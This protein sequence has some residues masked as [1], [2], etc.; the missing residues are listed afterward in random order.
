MAQ[1][2]TPGASSG[3]ATFTYPVSDGALT[4][5][6]TVTVTVTDPPAIGDVSGV[7]EIVTT[8]TSATELAGPGSCDASDGDVDRFYLTISQTGL[9]LSARAQSGE[10]VTGSI[11]SGTGLATLTGMATFIEPDLSNPADD[12]DTTSY[13]D[14]HALVVSQPTPSTMTGSLTTNESWSG[15]TG[16]TQTPQCDIVSSVAGTF[17]YRHTETENYS[18]V[19]G[20][21]LF[22]EEEGSDGSFYAD[23]EGFPF[24]IEISGSTLN[25]HFPDEF[26]P[27]GT[28]TISAQSFEPA[29]GYFTF[30]LDITEKYGSGGVFD[31]SETEHFVA[32]GIFVR[33]PAL[34]NGAD[35]APLVFVSG[36]GFSRHYTGEVGNGGT[37][38][39]AS[40]DYT[41]G[42]GKRLTTAGQ[43][44]TILIEG[45]DQVDRSPI[46]VGLDNPPLKRLNTTTSDLWIEVLNAD[47]TLL[48]S[49]LYTYDGTN[50]LGSPDSFRYFEQIDQPDPDF[51]ALA[52]RGD[53]YSTANCITSALTGVPINDGDALTI[54]VLDTV[55][56]TKET[57]GETL[58]GDDVIAFTTSYTAEVATLGDRF[59]QSNKVFDINVNGAT[60]STTLG[61]GVPLYGFFNPTQPL[62]VSWPAD[63][64]VDNFQLRLR[65][66]FDFVINRLNT[67]TAT[68]VV[69][70]A[71]T[72]DDDYDVN[73]RLLS[74]D[75]TTSN[76]AIAATFSRA[77][78][79]TPGIM[80]LFNIELGSA[81]PLS[82]Q[83][84]QLWIEGDENFADCVDAGFWPATCTGATVNYAG[85]TV[86]LS[87]TD[88]G[89]GT[90]TGTPGGGFSLVLSFSDSKV[91]EVFSADGIPGVPSLANGTTAAMVA[92]SEF[93]LRTRRQSHNGNER[94]RLNI[95][96][97]LALTYTQAVLSREDGAAF[98]SGGSGAAASVVLWD[99]NAGVPI[100]YLDVATEFTTVPTDD[101]EAQRT[102][103]MATF[104]TNDLGF[105]NVVLASGVYRLVLTDQLGTE[106]NV[107]FRYNYTAPSAANFI[108]PDDLTFTL[109][110]TDCSVTP[111]CNNP[112]A[113]VTVTATPNISWDVDAS[114]P[115]GSFWRF[116]FRPTG[117]GV[118]ESLGQIRS[119][120]MLDG[121][122]G[123]S[124]VGTTAT[125]TNPGSLV[126]PSGDYEVQ[127]FII[128]GD[129]GIGSTVFGATSGPSGVGGDLLY[130]T[131]P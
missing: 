86:T 63:A 94:T 48:C 104:A 66:P 88:D 106:P 56:G 58:A 125:W 24:E 23:Q 10:L 19:Y 85:N 117:T 74:F 102:K 6:A 120:Y 119:P 131:V 4:A 41:F 84:F 60:T 108:A 49:N 42:Y 90:Y 118:N 54:R 80:G 68:S 100:P 129:S 127:L 107:V 115:A 71:N 121:V 1:T 73:L 9:N 8:V 32:T 21:E 92:N 113:P 38:D 30:T 111:F 72:L 26:D 18:G 50:P 75:T 39:F 87:M 44:R 99:E 105:G 112:A 96:N 57:T 110:G 78:N 45:P 3:T 17:I 40:V 116:A 33:D 98:G 123:F 46:L 28:E 77:M 61:G 103:Q 14:T 25:I 47:G 95:V 37:P 81:L 11:D 12:T 7:W 5:T 22:T 43:T 82:H 64:K 114:V 51:S 20:F 67:G 130:I 126:L 101:G 83:T 53:R 59:T 52:F 29:T 89:S 93:F 79:L 122:F 31:G 128:N 16:T 2:Y 55:N 69:I 27:D 70:P 34:T 35:G 62:T 65:E 15:T 97:P 91:A 13:E 76:G 36:E 109:D 124:I